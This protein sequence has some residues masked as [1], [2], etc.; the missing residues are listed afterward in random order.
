MGPCVESCVKSGALS[1][2]RSDGDG[3]TSIG[4]PARRS[5]GAV[6][7]R[8]ASKL[9]DFSAPYS[10][11]DNIA[12]HRPSMQIH[13]TNIWLLPGPALPSNPPHEILVCFAGPICVRYF[14]ENPTSRDLWGT[15][16]QTVG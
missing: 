3:R 12:V 16:L 11:W 4:G 14:T 6:A 1:P 9:L 15:P 8:I 13:C 5:V 7:A 2:S 10:C